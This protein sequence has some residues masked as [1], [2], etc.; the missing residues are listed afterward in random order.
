MGVDRGELENVAGAD[1]ADRDVI[2][3]IDG[4]REAR[5]DLWSLKAGLREDQDLRRDG[6]VECAQ[7]GR[8][9]PMVGIVVEMSLTGCEFLLEIGDAVVDGA[10]GE[11]DG[12]IVERQKV[13]FVDLREETACER[14]GGEEDL[15]HEISEVA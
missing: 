8:Q 15:D 12:R 6:D 10:A 3:V 14:E 1:E 13:E 2:G 9:V 4:A 11:A 5:T 7:H